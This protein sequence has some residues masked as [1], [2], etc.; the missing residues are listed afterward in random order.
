[1]RFSLLDRLVLTPMLLPWVPFRSFALKGWLAGAAL[2]ALAVYGGGMQLRNDAFLLAAAFLFF[3]ALSSYI[4][5]QF[6][7][8]TT[9]TGIS[10][11]N[12]ELKIGIPLYLGAAG[13]S[14]VLL[15]LFKVREWGYL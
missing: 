13:L 11:V 12:K 1:M 6:T 4:A 7:G 5:L 15:V 9:F 10:G 8:S 3:P 2:L 14:V